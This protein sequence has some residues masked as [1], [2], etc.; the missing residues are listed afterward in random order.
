MP[1]DGPGVEI[2][3]AVA[4][5]NVNPPRTPNTG[6]TGVGLTCAEVPGSGKA[7][8]GEMGVLPRKGSVKGKDVGQPPLWLCGEPVL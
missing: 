5:Q 2:W 7:E 4:T 3:P 6:R 8:E 1:C